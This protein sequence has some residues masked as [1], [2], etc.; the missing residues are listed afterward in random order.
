MGADHDVLRW[1]GTATAAGAYSVVVRQTHPL[2]GNTGGFRDTTVA[3]T[4]TP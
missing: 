3:L 2:A 1:D 4:L